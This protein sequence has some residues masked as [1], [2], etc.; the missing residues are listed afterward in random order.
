M[1]LNPPTAV[2]DVDALCALFDRLSDNGWS[3]GPVP[4]GEK[5]PRF[6]DWQQHCR[7][8]MSRRRFRH[9]VQSGLGGSLCIFGG[10]AVGIDIDVD[11]PEL[12][13]R[14][15]TV[16][17]GML[18]ETP[19][20]RIGRA[21]RVLLVYGAGGA[22]KS[23]AVRGGD[24][25]LIEV[26]GH[27]GQF[28][29]FGRHSDTGR[30]YDWTHESPETVRLEEVPAVTAKQVDLFLKAVQSLLPP[31]PKPTR[32][33][34]GSTTAQ[35]VRDED[36]RVIDG[37][38]ALLLEITMAACSKAHRLGRQH[39]LARLEREVWQAFRDQADLSRP[40][41][42]GNAWS[43]DHAAAEVGYT[44][45]RLTNGTLA[46]RISRKGG[47]W[48]LLRKQAYVREARC[49]GA[50]AGEIAVLE[51]MLDDLNRNGADLCCP[52]VGRIAT[53][54]GLSD[55]TVQRHKMRLIERGLVSVLGVHR[56]YKTDMLAF[57]LSLVAHIGVEVAEQSVTVVSEALPVTVAAPTPPEK[58]QVVVLEQ[59]GSGP[60]TPDVTLNHNEEKDLSTGW[61]ARIGRSANEN[62]PASM[63][64]TPTPPPPSV[65]MDLF[66]DALAGQRLGEL[67]RALRRERG[68][69]QR[70]VARALGLSQPH[71]ANIE[72]GH[73]GAS[74]ATAARLRSYI[75]GTDAACAGGR[76]GTAPR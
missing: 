22:V 72:R 3:V 59:K 48:T 6:R 20:R 14:I 42:D 45:K 53:K 28:M 63:K 35:I 56:R 26:K 15:E 36:G 2:N 40:R 46:P 4:S 73:D 31:V 76:A 67:V 12:V 70:D 74:P 25:T 54:T 64:R 75:A 9:L 68:H 50:S 34:K 61:E 21:P 11:D 39:E 57:D 69:K 52:S 38:R 65:H 13:R 8:R 7:R 27:G 24:G 10:K 55:R 58:S 60:P 33:S 44:L 43:P 29:A 16:A 32:A 23:K 18:G 41:S 37:R 30:D 66:D 71:L 51:A 1:T 5:G 47:E 17:H 49:L 62:V 19:L